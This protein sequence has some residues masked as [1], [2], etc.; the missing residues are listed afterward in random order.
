MGSNRKRIRMNKRAFL[1]FS[2]WMRSESFK[3]EATLFVAGFCSL[4]YLFV[5]RNQKST[6][7][8]PKAPLIRNSMRQLVWLKMKAQ[9]GTATT[10]PIAEPP[11][12]I[13]FA[14][15]CLWLGIHSITAF[16]APGKHPPSPTPSKKR[17]AP[18]WNVFVERACKA[19]A[20]DQ[21]PTE[22]ASPRRLPYLSINTPPSVNMIA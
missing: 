21:N 19:V 6:Q 8:I 18:K 1:F 11:M 10:A 12:A 20:K 14:M 17:N 22:N 15:A 3:G 13:P 16:I 5:S 7:I 2:K 9:R 4:E